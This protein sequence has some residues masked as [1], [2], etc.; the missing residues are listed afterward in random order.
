MADAKK[1]GRLAARIA[2]LRERFPALDRVLRVQEHY[3]HIE[4]GVLASSATYFGFL[5]FFPLLALAFAV[6]GYV[7]VAFP[8]ARDHLITAIEELFPGIV[9]ESGEQGTISLTQIENAKATVGL[10]GF[11]GVLYSGLGWVS[12]LRTALT[13]AF[14]VPRERARNFVV[15]K[16]VDVVT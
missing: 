7:S 6:V 8:D 3:S 13:D 1:P 2:A 10:I 12:G 15:G 4:G 14:A 9:S 16:A 11:V 5:S